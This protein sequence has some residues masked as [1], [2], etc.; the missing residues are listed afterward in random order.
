MGAHSK[1]MPN[2]SLIAAEGDGGDVCMVRLQLIR[3]ITAADGQCHI[4]QEIAHEVRS[5]E[6][7]EELGAQVARHGA[8]CEEHPKRA[9]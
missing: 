7:A 1:L 9:L 8:A 4:K 6:E 2:S 3:T 5:L